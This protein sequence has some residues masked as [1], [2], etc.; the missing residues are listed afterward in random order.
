MF[1][2]W[3]STPFGDIYIAHV[4]FIMSEQIL[5]QYDNIVYIDTSLTVQMDS[6]YPV[7]I[8][9]VIVKYAAAEKSCPVIGNN[10]AAVQE[11]NMRYKQYAIPKYVNINMY[12]VLYYSAKL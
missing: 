8:F 9:N 6:N 4:T 2:S 7:I 3:L 11:W 5:L 1:T 10:L 12:I